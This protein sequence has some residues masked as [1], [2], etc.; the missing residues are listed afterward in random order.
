MSLIGENISSRCPITYFLDRTSSS[1]FSSPYA[2]SSN[3]SSYCKQSVPRSI[4]LIK[5]GDTI[6]VDLNGPDMNYAKYNNEAEYRWRMNYRWNVLQTR[7][8]QLD[9]SSES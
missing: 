7:I 3:S 6:M 1:S 8:C 5:I 4:K 2:S 9:I